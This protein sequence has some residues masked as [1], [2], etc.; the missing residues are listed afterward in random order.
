MMRY[1]FLILYYGFAT[2]LPDSYS[3]FIGKISNSI[4][5]FLCRRIF[6]KCGK[7]KII[8][9]R[10]AYFGNGKDIEIGDF[11]SIGAETILPNNIIIGKY[12]MMAPY[13]H[14]LA[15][16]HCFDRTDI[17]ICFQGY[18]PHQAIE[19]EDDCWIGQRVIIIPNRKVKKGTIIATGAVVTKDYEEYS[20]IG[21]N[22]ARLIRKRI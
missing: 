6:K 4:R 20:I 11:S 15:N 9:N 22:P 19:I 5:I 18:S 10:K 21:G 3:P 16:N 14:I 13:V 2:Y 1:L 17:P 12:V 7:E 8:I